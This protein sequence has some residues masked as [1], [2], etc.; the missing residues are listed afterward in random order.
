MDDD[1]P[2]KLM[3]VGVGASAGGLEAFGDLL[4][5]L[6]STTG[7]AF[8]LVQHLDPHHESVLPELLAGKTRMPVLQVQNETRIQ[9]DHVYV[10]PPNTQMRMRDRVLMLSARP[11]TPPE[12]F[13]PIDVFFNSLAEEL[14]YNA[15]G[16]VLSGTA[17]DGTLGLKTIKAEGGITFAQNETAK[18]DSMP[19]SAIAAG[20]VD[21]VLPPRRI[22][23]ELVAI[24]H[25]TT[26]LTL[27]DA[28]EAG[29]GSTLHRILQLV[30]NST[31]VDFT[32]Y[33]QPTILRRLNRRMVLRNAES[34][35]KY[36]E[37]LQ[38]EREE[39]KALFDDLLINV[40]DFFRDPE[41]F[42]TAK[43]LA[44]PALVRDSKPTGVIRAWIPGCST[45]EEVYSMVIALVEFLESEELPYRVQ[46]FGTDVSDT[47]I[48]KAR[49]AIYAESAMANVS[50]ER[51][52]RF[53][54]RADSGYQISRTIRDMCIFSRHNVA[55][56]PALSR[57]DL[58]SCR[59]LLIYFSPTLQ[60]RIL[61]TFGYSLQP[62][63]CLILGSSETL[64]S[65]SEYF[66]PLDE[67]HK[68]Y[69]RKSNAAQG[70]YPLSEPDGDHLAAHLPP[71]PP[72]AAPRRLPGPIRG[73]AISTRRPSRGMDRPPWW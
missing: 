24:A 30:R 64:G 2:D 21:F 36:Y 72:S 16:V 22:A 41:V 63:G 8:V 26:R 19:R 50:P 42:E 44:F 3:V 71:P 4:R 70:V 23:E 73:S 5:Y 58:V 60:R 28:A 34:V 49:A 15:I 48:E 38:K 12:S 67:S 69:C 56:D 11:T 65:L 52:R 32:Q 45:G 20:A 68:I 40:T 54:V 55:K 29:D 10:I 6:P 46:M 18:F 57:M 17:S 47:T 62:G 43:R 51:L 59:N 25:R 9:P 39:I 37:I 7:M 53:F 13:K 1:K 35:E 61:N 14:H 33:K 27:P 31:G 66:Q